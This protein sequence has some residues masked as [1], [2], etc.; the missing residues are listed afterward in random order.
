MGIYDREYVRV[1]PTSKSGLGS[2]RLISVNSWIIIINVAV[3]LLDVLTAGSALP[4]PI[5][6]MKVQNGADLRY[7]QVEPVLR[8]VTGAPVSPQMLAQRSAG[9]AGTIR[10]YENVVDTR[11]RI[12]VGVQ[13]VELMTPA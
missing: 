9:R 2:L 6:L 12:P 3:F 8:D 1:G 13:P 4:V 5:D 7:V 10:L 11:T